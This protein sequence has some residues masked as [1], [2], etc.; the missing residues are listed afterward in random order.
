EE[1]E[2][3]AARLS[4]GPRPIPQ[5][6][7]RLRLPLGRPGAVWVV[8]ELNIAIYVIPTLLQFMGVRVN[9][10][11]INDYLLSIGAK[12]NAGIKQRGEYYRFLTSMFLHGGL[13]H[14]AFNAWALYALGPE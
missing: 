12:D 6:T 10:V 14:I 2:R 8:L 11:P 3:G 1:R 9:G 5:Q 7:Y 4:A 13:L